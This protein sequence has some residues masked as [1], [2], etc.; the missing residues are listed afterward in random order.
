MTINCELVDYPNIK[1]LSF[2]GDLGEE[3]IL[4]R[5]LQNKTGVAEKSF[6]RK[7]NRTRKVLKAYKMFRH[8]LRT[9]Y[10]TEAMRELLHELLFTEK[11][12]WMFNS[13]QA[14]NYTEVT[15]IT[16]E[17]EIT[18]QDEL[19]ESEIEIEYYE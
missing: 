15:V 11:E 13:D 17:T 10:E 5:G 7:A 4:F 2:V 1:A 14:A 12:V 6:T 18:N 3:T 16:D 8:I 19:I 9:L